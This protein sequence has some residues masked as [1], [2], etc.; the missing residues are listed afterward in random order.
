MAGDLLCIRKTV[1][2]FQLVRQL[3]REFLSPEL[4]HELGNRKY[5]IPIRKSAAIQSFDETDPVDQLFFSTMPRIVNTP[6]Y[7]WPTVNELIQEAMTEFLYSDRSP[8][9]FSAELTPALE[10]I[11]KY[12]RNRRR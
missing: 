4:Q 5:G 8:Q 12:T 7:A 11:L 3:I 10:A 9:E 6:H 2:N 1:N